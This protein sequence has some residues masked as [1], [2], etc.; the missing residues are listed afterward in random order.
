MDINDLTVGQVMDIKSLFSGGSVAP[1]YTEH[2]KCGAG[3]GM[4]GKSVIVRTYSAG[5]WFG[6]LSEK[7]RSEVVLI[8]ARRMYRWWATESI[9]LSAVA[10]YGIKQDKSEII[11]AVD[12]VWL[13][14]IEIIPCS[15][16]AKASIEGAESVKAK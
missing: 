2:A 7:S 15:P 6:E 3:V 8:N 11:E 14:A 16:L 1:Q 13:D 9:S 4:I 5:N 10:I 12:S